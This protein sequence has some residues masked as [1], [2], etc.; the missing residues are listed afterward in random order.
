MEIQ[1]DVHFL[2]CDIDKDGSTNI[3]AYF[4][5]TQTSEGKLRSQLRG[6][7]LQG[8]VLSLSKE[9]LPVQG[10]VATKG[11]LTGEGTKLEITGRFESI[12]VWQ[13]DSKPDISQIREYL[14]WFE[15]SN[16][17]HG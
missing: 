4:K 16:A 11:Q 7:D 15:I 3:K 6:H 17:V 12:T 13:H 5:V 10:I 14:D 8:D 2:P 9:G 1:S